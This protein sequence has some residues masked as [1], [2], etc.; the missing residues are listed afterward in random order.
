MDMALAVKVICIEQLAE[1]IRRTL[2]LSGFKKPLPGVDFMLNR[3]KTF[4]LQVISIQVQRTSSCR[5]GFVKQKVAN[6]PLPVAA[7][8]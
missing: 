3:C 4:L 7:S 1:R 6:P 8:V 2:P 5:K